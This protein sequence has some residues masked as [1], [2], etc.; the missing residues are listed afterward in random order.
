MHRVCVTSSPLLA[1]GRLCWEFG[2]WF[3]TRCQPATM[4]ILFKI[5]FLKTT[6]KEMLQS[7]IHE[8]Y[9]CLRAQ[10]SLGTTSYQDRPSGECNAL[11]NRSTSMKS[12]PTDQWNLRKMGQHSWKCF[13]TSAYLYLYRKMS[14][15]CVQQFSFSISIN[16]AYDPKRE[17]RLYFLTLSQIYTQS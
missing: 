11:D 1:C 16:I 12:P 14:L 8:I 13:L 5:T 4:R 10:V 6:L 9:R 17:H 2:P 3:D 7:F 15:C